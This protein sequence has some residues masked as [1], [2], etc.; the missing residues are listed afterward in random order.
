MVNDKLVS[1]VTGKLADASVVLALGGMGTTQAEL[2]ASLG[3]LADRAPFP[4]IA[5]PGDLESATA[6]AGAAKALRAR[7]QIVIDGRL[8]H[9]VELDGFWLDRIPVTN[10]QLGCAQRDSTPSATACGSSRSSASRKTTN[11]PRL[12]SSPR[13]RADGAPPFSC[14]TQRTEG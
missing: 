8:V 5:L 10:A 7:G 2:E 11:S 12:A 9:T 14:L 4:V 1:E 13:L 6:L 3:A